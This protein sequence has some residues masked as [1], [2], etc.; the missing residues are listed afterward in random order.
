MPRDGEH[1]GVVAL[2]ERL[3]R[4]LVACAQARDELGLGLGGPVLE[5]GLGH[6]PTL[7]ALGR[8]VEGR[9]ESGAGWTAAP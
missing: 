4:A 8:G 6:R 1:G 3:E 9:N 2:D 7:T 5:S